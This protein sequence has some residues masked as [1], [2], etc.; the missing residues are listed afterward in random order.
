MKPWSK[1]EDK[2]SKEISD[3]IYNHLFITGEYAEKY[4]TQTIEPE[5][6]TY[7]FPKNSVYKQTQVSISKMCLIDTRTEKRV[8]GSIYYDVDDDGDLID[9]NYLGYKT[10]KDA[11]HAMEIYVQ[12]ILDNVKRWE[13][14]EN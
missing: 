12:G 4:D 1:A 5:V 13:K 11:K 10:L 7:I 6:E 3:F 8:T 9:E 14:K 2:R